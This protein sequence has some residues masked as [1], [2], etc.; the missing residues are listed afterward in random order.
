MSQTDPIA[1]LLTRI[2]NAMR[3]R[4]NELTVPHSRLREAICRVL[5]AEGF[6]AGVEAGLTSKTGKVGTIGPV[7]YPEAHRF[8][9]TLRQKAMNNQGH[10]L[11][12]P[13]IKKM[14]VRCKLR[15]IFCAG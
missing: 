14:I 8:T 7:D 9:D 10:N 15:L 4:Y 11:T 5:M 1:E 12:F 13:V 3:A 6:L 2:R